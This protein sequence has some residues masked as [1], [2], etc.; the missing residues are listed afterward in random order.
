MRPLKTHALYCVYRKQTK[1]GYFWYVRFWDETSRK[2]TRI[3]STGIPVKGRG[4]GRHD[5]EEVREIS[6]VSADTG[7]FSA[8]EIEAVEKKTIDFVWYQYQICKN[9]RTVWGNLAYFSIFA[10]NIIIL[11]KREN[12]HGKP[13]KPRPILPL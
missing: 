9:Q 13:R 5:A 6:D 10:K 3:R 4:E 12:S 1:A 11:A 2:Y 7:F 8:K